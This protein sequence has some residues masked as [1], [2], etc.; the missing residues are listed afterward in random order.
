MIWL[1][2]GAAN[3]LERGDPLQLNLSANIAYIALRKNLNL[4][5]GTW[6]NCAHRQRLNHQHNK[7]LIPLVWQYTGGV[8]AV[9]GDRLRSYFFA[10]KKISETLDSP[11]PLP[12]K[13]QT[14]GIKAKNGVAATLILTFY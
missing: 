11:N 12:V 10:R 1:I 6:R 14:R 3:A 7:A 13:M 2:T 4:Y 5:A 8:L 9:K